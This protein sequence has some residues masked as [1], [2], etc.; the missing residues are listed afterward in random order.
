MVYIAF[1]ANYSNETSILFNALNKKYGI[2]LILSNTPSNLNTWKNTLGNSQKDPLSQS[3]NPFPFNNS[4]NEIVQHCVSNY[5]NIVI[6]LNKDKSVYPNMIVINCFNIHQEPQSKI[7]TSCP[8]HLIYEFE[9]LTDNDTEILNKKLG[10]SMNTHL[11]SRFSISFSY[12]TKDL[13]QDNDLQNFLNFIYN[14][15]SSMSMISQNE[16][17]LLFKAPIKNSKQTTTTRFNLPY[18]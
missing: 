2:D 8:E 14:N 11:K 7:G 18:K 12:Q 6:Q 3:P 9:V 17:L 15:N 5:C 13:V 16:N 1:L 10:F 4:F